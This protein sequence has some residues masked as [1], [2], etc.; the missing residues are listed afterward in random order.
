M[1]ED[2]KKRGVL[3]GI[4]PDPDKGK[5][6]RHTRRKCL[7]M[8]EGMNGDKHGAALKLLIEKRP[9]DVLDALIAVSD[10]LKREDPDFATPEDYPQ[11]L[12][13]P[14]GLNWHGSD[15]RNRGRASA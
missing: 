3:G 12:P 13:E 15:Y 8:M 2:T 6:Y 4:E 14:V 7:L 5:P 10:E 11:S 9:E 1:T